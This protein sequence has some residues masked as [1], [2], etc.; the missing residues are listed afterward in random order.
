MTSKTLYPLVCCGC[1]KVTGES[2]VEHSS[3]LCE[4]CEDAWRAR[5]GLPPP[6]SRAAQ[7]ESDEEGRS[8][9]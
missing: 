5:E 3:S 8:A 2:E 4:E 7:Q 1:G 9:V 6:G